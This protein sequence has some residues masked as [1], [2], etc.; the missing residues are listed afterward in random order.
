[1]DRPVTSMTQ[2]PDTSMSVA[3]TAAASTGLTAPLAV[4]KVR[5][6]AA[7][8]KDAP[9]A[10][11]VK[12]AATG[13]SKN[14]SKSSS[15]TRPQ[16]NRAAAKTEGDDLDNITSGIKKI[17]I[18]TKQQKEARA[19]EKKQPVASKKSM[20]SAESQGL[21]LPVTPGEEQPQD[22]TLPSKGDDQPIVT[23]PIMAPD[24]LRQEPP[25]TPIVDSVEE[26]DV[27]VETPMDLP[28]TEQTTTSEVFV[29]YQPDGPTPEAITPQ[30]PLNWLPVNSSATPSPQKQGAHVP[31]SSPAKEEERAVVSPN[32]MQRGELPVFTPTSQLRFAP[33]TGEKSSALSTSPRAKTGAER[34]ADGAKWEVPETPE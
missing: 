8:K 4:K 29:Q 10:P 21:S 25:I 28:L 24:V 15:P 9:K 1:M 22:L 5:T 7:P 16:S 2:R 34:K 33:R 17:T 18:L 32:P 12:K 31:K 11:R 14:G 26:D 27:K 30:G 23:N 3:T 19:R 20:S 13:A 6:N